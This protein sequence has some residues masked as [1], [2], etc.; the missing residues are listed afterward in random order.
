LVRCLTK[1][2]KERPQKRG[3]S[4]NFPP[5]RSRKST[6]SWGPAF[7][8]PL[9]PQ[10][11]K[12][13]RSF[14]R[15]FTNDL[16]KRDA[17]PDIPWEEL[18]KGDRDD[19]AYGHRH[20]F[21]PVARAKHEAYMFGKPLTEVEGEGEPEQQEAL[22]P[23]ADSSEVEEASEE[24]TSIQAK[25]DCEKKEEEA[26]NLKADASA[27]AASEPESEEEISLK[28]DSPTP[29]ASEQDSEEEISLK[30]DSPAPITSEQDSEEEISLKAD[31]PAPITS[32]PES[33]E[34][35]SLKADSSAPIASEQDSEEEISLKADSSA[36]ITSEPESE[37]EISLKADSPAPITNEQDSEE[38]ISLKADSPQV[39]DPSEE[40]D[41]SQANI[42]PQLK[43][44]QPGDKYEQEADSKAA[45]V[46]K[47]EDPATSNEIEE[48]SS[49]NAIQKQPLAETITPLVQRKE[50]I[51]RKG[52]PTKGNKLSVEKQLGK[53]GGQP[54]GQETR[55]F[56][57]SRF[58]ADFSGVRVHTDSAAVQMNKDLGAQ[59]FTHGQDVYYGSG[60]SP[61]KNEL[62]AH[63]LT[64]T[65]Q[66]N[67]GNIQAKNLDKKE[68]KK[69]N[70]IQ[71]KSLPCPKSSAAPTA[72][73]SLEKVSQKQSSPE[74]DAPERDGDLYAIVDGG[75][76]SIPLG[77]GVLLVIVGAA[78]IVINWRDIN[79]T[80]TQLGQIA[81]DWANDTTQDV[82]SRIINLVNQ[83]G[84]AARNNLEGFRGAIEAV[85]GPLLSRSRGRG[86]GD[87]RA[88]EG[89]SIKDCDTA[90]KL[91]TQYARLA[92]NHSGRIPR[93][94]LEELNRL[95]DSGTIR[96]SDLPG[97]LREVFPGIFGD[98]T[99]NEIREMCNRRR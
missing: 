5:N 74:T 81:I 14:R 21:D 57:E 90:I 31:S 36:P 35:I 33:E 87:G 98:K 58:G 6:R 39:E 12:R 92:Q 48:E 44:G 4:N 23:K 43:I 16:P 52:N 84:V 49:D 69:N 89:P 99:L 25:C 20:I 15:P 86:R 68:S 53:G 40:A 28:A 77:I 30:A 93:S 29:T 50:A 55:S 38:E 2:M 66:Q 32:E 72:L 62:T 91:L 8:E 88:R 9:W 82:T 37:E 96:R 11:E 45:E 41:L 97:G 22:H 3:F 19:T 54:L 46:M 75:V 67:G 51:Q 10:D 95:R 78:G 18:V 13:N 61:G 27:L 7:G 70:K 94:R 17:Q 76:I 85:I 63:E 59:A 34:E 24:E 56:M 60:K 73:T 64:H 71:A 83:A 42:Q 79:G 80:I 65:I 47:M 26:V 1:S